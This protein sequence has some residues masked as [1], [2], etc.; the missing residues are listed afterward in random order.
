MMFDNCTSIGY[1]LLHGVAGLMCG[2]VTKKLL[3]LNL[4][5]VHVVPSFSH[6]IDH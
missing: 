3:R 1:A 2:R 5:I 6:Q 4:S